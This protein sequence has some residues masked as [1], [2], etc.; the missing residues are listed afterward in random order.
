MKRA[1]VQKLFVYD[2]K[3]NPVQG[4]IFLMLKH[5]DYITANYHPEDEINCFIKRHC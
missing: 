5:L 1:F 4:L 2:V 3:T